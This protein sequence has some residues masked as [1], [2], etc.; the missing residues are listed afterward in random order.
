MESSNR[1]PRFTG[2]R[3]RLSRAWIFRGSRSFS[4]GQTAADPSVCLRRSPPPPQRNSTAGIKKSGNL[5][6]FLTGRRF[7]SQD[8]ASP[9]M[10][11]GRGEVP[12]LRAQAVAKCSGCDQTTWR[13]FSGNLQEI[14]DVGESIADFESES[15]DKLLF[16]PGQRQCGVAWKAARPV[17]CSAGE[18]VGY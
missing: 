14:A 13:V 4:S 9:L 12:L 11:I 17:P 16:Q 3:G 8:F 10:A 1:R 15:A 7:E 6:F 18:L 5:R 2:Y